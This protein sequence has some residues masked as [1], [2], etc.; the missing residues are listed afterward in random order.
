MTPL[1]ALPYS[2]SHL[3]VRIHHH[4]IISLLCTSWVGS[5]LVEE[6]VESVA[7]LAV[8][9]PRLL[10]T[11]AT[12][13]SATSPIHQVRRVLVVERVIPERGRGNSLRLRRQ[14]IVEWVVAVGHREGSRLVT[15]YFVQRLTS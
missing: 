1:I 4:C 7:R 15:D 9:R 13:R 10:V 8:A 3:R 12:R 11:Y 6:G 14:D 2:L 5:S